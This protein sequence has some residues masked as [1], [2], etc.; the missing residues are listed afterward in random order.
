MGKRFK[1]ALSYAKKNP[2]RTAAATALATYG[3]YKGGKHLHGMYKGYRANRDF[4]GGKSFNKEPTKEYKKTTIEVPI[5]WKDVEIDGKIAKEP[6]AWQT[7]TMWAFGRYRRHRRSR[8][9]RRR[10]RRSR[11]RSRRSRRK[12]SRRKR[13]RRRRSRRRRSRRRRSRRRRSRRRRRRSR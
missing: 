7:K 11:R 5:K 6:V 4:A 13:S 3:I 2:F 9:S 1:R 12:R 8:R 10:S